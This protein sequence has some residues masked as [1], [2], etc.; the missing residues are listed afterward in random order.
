MLCCFWGTNAE[1]T[2]QPGERQVPFNSA[3]AGKTINNGNDDDNNNN[4]NIKCNWIPTARSSLCT[5]LGTLSH[6]RRRRGRIAGAAGAGS[7]AERC[8]PLPEAPGSAGS[9]RA[10]QE[11]AG[12]WDRNRLQPCRS[13]LSST[14]LQQR[15]RPQAP[16]G[17]RTGT[18]SERGVGLLCLC[19]LPV[20][21]S[22]EQC[23]ASFWRISPHARLHF[24]SYSC[25]LTYKTT[26]FSPK[27]V[28][29]N[30]IP[31]AKNLL[32]DQHP[33]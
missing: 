14:G 19:T 31:A 24:S 29:D 30:T 17:P 11:P 9:E 22:P 28:E 1:V 15:A 12:L 23:I 21:I 2:P 18:G 27:E 4:N 26:N 10:E 20:P 3:A 8:L 25:S 33:S 5:L 13:P 6:R 16:P 7:G 32:H